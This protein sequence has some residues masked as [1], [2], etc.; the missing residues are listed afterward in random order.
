LVAGGSGIVPLMSMIR[1]CASMSSTAPFRLLYSVRELEAVYYRDELQA[2]PTRDPA[3]SIAY[4]YTRSVPKDWPQLPGRINTF[5]IADTALSPKLGNLLVTFAGP[6][7]F[8]ET[9]AAL[10]TASGH[11]PQKIKTERFGSAGEQK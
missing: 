2:L 8:V 9:A 6:T 1:S 4:A 11:D 3:V 10:L 5:L 7:S